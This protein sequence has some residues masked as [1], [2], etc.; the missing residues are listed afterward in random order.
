MNVEFPPRLEDKFYLTEGGTETEVM[1][2]WGF[3]LPEFAMFPLLDNAEADTVIRTMYRR[4][5]D[6]AAEQGTGLL[7]NGHDYRASPDWGEKLGYSAQG[8]RDM[9]R[10]TIGF[11]DEMRSE[12]ADRVS[13]VYIAACIGPRGD[14]Y[15][16]GG[17]I[18]ADE[19]EDYHSVQLCNL[20]GTAADMAVAATFNNVPEAI[21]VI[22]AAIG[23]GMPIGVS[24]TLTP[25]GRL[26]SGPSLREAIESIDEATAGSATWFGTN[27]SH[28]LE[29]EPAL[30]DTGAW[31]E[32]LRYI[33]PNAARMDKI[34]LCSL[35]HLED[36]DP[37][38]LGEQMG[39][40]AR[41]LPNAD[42]IGGCCGTDERHL[43]EIAQNVNAVRSARQT[44]AC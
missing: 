18:T 20:D 6:V 41:R 30:A 36:G 43:S 38:E 40:V 29:F 15:G 2:K 13:D 3:E 23:V 11:L 7:L 8:L 39:E 31:L 42:I 21:G 5:L 12:Y 17:E 32:R 22:R 25:E 34:A 37:V 4:Y 9:Q 14:A 19:A 28:P 16:T 1:Y 24:L 26:R 35:G 44:A 33:R 27:C 10:R